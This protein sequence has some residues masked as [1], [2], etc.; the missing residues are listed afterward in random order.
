MTFFNGHPHYLKKIAQKCDQPK[1]YQ[2]MIST[3][4]CSK[5]KELN[6][7]LNI[8]FDPS[9]SLMLINLMKNQML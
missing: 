3:Y 8:Q 5:K 6:F 7:D 1:K 2:H 9:K 4:Y